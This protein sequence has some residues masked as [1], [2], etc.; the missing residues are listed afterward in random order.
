MIVAAGC[1]S[2]AKHENVLE[3]FATK[4][5]SG[6]ILS[7]NNTENSPPCSYW[8]VLYVLDNDTFSEKWQY[9]CSDIF[10]SERVLRIKKT[11]KHSYR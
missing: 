6:N 10:D 9:C 2:E 7:I 11:G 3:D 1:C 8:D 4:H 5:P